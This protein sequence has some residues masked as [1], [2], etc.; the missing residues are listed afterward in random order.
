M[1]S[2]K[3][4]VRRLR[5]RMTMVFQQFNLVTHEVLENVTVALKTAL[6][7][8]KSEANGINTV[9]LSCPA[10]CAAQYPCMA[11]RLSSCSMRLCW[12]E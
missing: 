12:Q 10:H 5:T 9:M 4:Q 3:T 1:V 2:D 7:L 6:K 8:S 11:M